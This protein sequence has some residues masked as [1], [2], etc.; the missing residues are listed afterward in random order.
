MSCQACRGYNVRPIISEATAVVGSSRS[1]EPE[2]SFPSDIVD[3]GQAILLAE[4]PYPG[5]SGFIPGSRGSL[6]LDVVFLAMFAVV[7][8]LVVSIYL[9]KYQRR[10]GL[11]KRLQLAMAVVL[12]I[13]VLLFELDIRV[14][15]WEARAEP[16]PYFDASNKWSCPAGVSLIVHLS[17]A[18]PTLLLWIYV[19]IAALRN[20]S[21]PPAPGLHS[22]AHSLTGMIAAAG[23]VLTAVTGWL[24]YWLAF[25]A[26]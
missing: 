3:T 6:M 7:P 10:Y 12:L 16:S 23:M 17:F 8:L 13:A 22:R 9:V 26:T 15:G 11:H 5:I 2:T 1:S 21:R 25:A 18:V 19:V 24:F 20:F 4:N 14:N